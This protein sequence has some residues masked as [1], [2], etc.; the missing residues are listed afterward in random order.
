[1]ANYEKS[2]QVMIEDIKVRR[3]YVIHRSHDYVAFSDFARKALKQLSIDNGY[4]YK[5]LE[6]YAFGCVRLSEKKEVDIGSLMEAVRHIR[7]VRI[8]G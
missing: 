6:N 2:R 1:M 3:E 7:W 8:Y 5:D 4:N